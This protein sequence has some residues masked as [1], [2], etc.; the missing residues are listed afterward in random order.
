MHVYLDEVRL[1]HV[2]VGYG[3][4]GV[5]GDL[6][7]ER[8]RVVVGGSS[9]D[10]ALSAHAPSSLLFD[11]DRSFST[12]ECRVALNDDVPFRGSYADFSVIADGNTVAVVPNVGA[13]EAPRAIVADITG[14]SKLALVADT[15][16][17]PHCHTVWV[18]PIVH[19]EARNSTPAADAL[20]RAD[21]QAPAGLLDAERCIAT[22]VSPGYAHLLDDM[23]ASLAANGRC[24]DAIKV[25]FSYNPD[26]QCRRVAEKHG[27][28]TITCRSRARMAPSLKAVVYSAARFV[29]AGNFLCLDA[30]TL[31]LGDLRPVFEAVH[32]SP[33]RSIL[34][35]RDAFLGQGSL[36]H[37]LCTH[38]AG[39]PEDFD[40]LLG[41]PFSEAEYPLAVNDGVFA[42]SRGALLALDDFIRT[43]PGAAAWV[44][45]RIDHGWRNQFIFNL[46]LA[47]MDCAVEL[48]ASYNLQVHMRDVHIGRTTTGVEAFWHGSPVRVLHFCGWGRDRYPEY[49]GLYASGQ[50][51]RPAERPVLT[52]VAAGERV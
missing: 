23:L 39:K 47:R 41:R 15:R 17:W 12:F 24:E 22:V 26:D 4:L 18:D 33:R 42:G 43:L 14:A 48:D 6:G 34:V 52:P 27:A 38:Y 29:N 2:D 35:C 37:E 46:A 11:L 50:C 40:L 30:D 8:S 1:L 5:R 31:V 36:L 19:N 45:Q 44:D 28:C 16:H 51:G 10:H 3:R 9:F 13:G 49:R 21:V 20:S 7:Y 25:V 32:A